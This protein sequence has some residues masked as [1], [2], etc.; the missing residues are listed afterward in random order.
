MY[1]GH[2]RKCLFVC[3]F[4]CLFLW[5]YVC[6]S[7]L[8]QELVGDQNVYVAL[9]MMIVLKQFHSTAELL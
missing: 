7:K 5:M 6:V 4:V 2:V 3:L 8:A 9:V 1:L